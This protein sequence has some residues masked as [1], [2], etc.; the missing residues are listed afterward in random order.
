VTVLDTN[1][2]LWLTQD[3]PRLG[4][5]AVRLADRALAEDCLVVSAFTFW[6]VC[7]LS[8]RG[9]L[10]LIQP[11]EAWREGLLELG[12]VEIPVTGEIA[13]EAGRFTDS[14]KDPA[15]RIIVATA[16]REGAL[17]LTG[18]EQ[19]LEWKGMLRRQDARL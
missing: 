19:I 7:T 2:L 14:L 4:K 18:D 12:L 17:L 6:E 13:I 8:Q 5:E 10:D 11:I 3:D 16:L 1:A 15:D 9:R